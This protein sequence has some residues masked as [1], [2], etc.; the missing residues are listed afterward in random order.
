MVSGKVGFGVFVF[1]ISERNISQSKNPKEHASLLSRYLLRVKRPLT[2]ALSP[3]S[4]G[5]GTRSQRANCL[6]IL[7]PSC[8]A[9]EN[10]CGLRGHRAIESQRSCAPFLEKSQWFSSCWLVSDIWFARVPCFS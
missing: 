1:L 10:G 6:P 4:R 3:Q 2:L 5:E 8:N 9:R 7:N